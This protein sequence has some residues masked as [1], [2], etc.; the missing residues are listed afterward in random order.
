VIARELEHC[1]RLVDAFERAHELFPRP[2]RNYDAWTLRAQK[3]FGRGWML[4]ASYT[5]SRL[6]GNYDGFVDR[7]TGAINLGESEQ[8]DI[9]QIVRN[10]FG[11]LNDDRPH[12]L[13]LDGYYTFSF[14]RFGHL[15]FGTS[16]RVMSGTPISYRVGQSDVYPEHG[17]L[18]PRGAAGR[19]PTQ[20]TW[21]LSAAYG[22][23]LGKILELELAMRVINVTN[24]KTVTRVEELYTY[25]FAPPIQGG[26][27]EDLK[28]AKTY[29]GAGS[30]GNFGEQ[31]VTPNPSFR[32]KL[33]YQQPVTGQA[34]LRLRF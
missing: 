8:F 9:P 2:T 13:K 27:L 6:I 19:T 10:S 20:S 24:A 26:D 18:L 30:S 14:K 32:A 33:T 1:N 7:D 22:Y 17:Y 34:E 29:A 23:P 12:L 28:H 16:L 4:I 5:Y 21:S 31:L 25:D 3:R 11:P 15:T